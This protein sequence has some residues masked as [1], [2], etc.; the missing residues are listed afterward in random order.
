MNNADIIGVSSTGNVITAGQPTPPVSDEKV[1]EVIDSDYDLKKQVI[2][3]LERA[4]VTT[5][6][7][8]AKILNVSKLKLWALRRKDPE[9]AEQINQAKEIIADKFEEELLTCDKM[10]QVVARLRSAQ[11][12]KT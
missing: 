10:A 8:V 5:L 7:A 1:K 6:S 4:E 9:F 12:I 11:D 2:A 3:E